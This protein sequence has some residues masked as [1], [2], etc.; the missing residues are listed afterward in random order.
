MTRPGPHRNRGQ[1]SAGTAPG[2]WSP[3]LGPRSRLLPGP[4]WMSLALRLMLGASE[5]P[6]GGGRYLSQQHLGVVGGR[7]PLPGWGLWTHLLPKF[8]H[9]LPGKMAVCCPLEPSIWAT[10]AHLLIPQLE[11]RRDRPVVPGLV[12]RGHWSDREMPLQERSPSTRRC[13]EGLLA[14]SRRGRGEWELGRCG[15]TL[16]HAHTHSHSHT[17][18][19]GT[20]TR[21]HHVFTHS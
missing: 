19:T 2:L 11:P 20:R 5:G 3:D 13:P 21:P 9:R 6:R 12:A 8:W 4:V 7:C 15:H 14:S 17:L 1:S 18:T 10:W 16:M